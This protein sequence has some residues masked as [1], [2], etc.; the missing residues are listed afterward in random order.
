MLRRGFDFIFCS[1]RPNTKIGSEVQ[2]MLNNIKFQE[3]YRVSMDKL[4]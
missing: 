4:E 2:V 3:S 1:K